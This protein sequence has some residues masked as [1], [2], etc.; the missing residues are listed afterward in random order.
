MRRKSKASRINEVLLLNP[1][2]SRNDSRIGELFAAEDLLKR[3]QEEAGKAPL[4]VQSASGSDKRHP[5]WVAVDNATDTVRRWRKELQLDRVSGKR[6]EA[7]GVKVKRSPKA[8]EIIA[9]GFDDFAASV[10][11]IPGYVGGLAAYGITADDVPAEHREL[12]ESELAA[13]AD[14]VPAIRN[15][16]RQHGM[17]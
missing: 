5:A 6:L 1:T 7:A 13:Q 16:L 10:Q 14:E 9:R 4:I 15:R 12:F 2:L 8:A 17:L 3:A 11:L